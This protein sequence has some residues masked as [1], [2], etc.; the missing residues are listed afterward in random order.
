[1]FT[2]ISASDRE[3]GFTLVELMVVIAIIGIMATMAVPNIISVMPRM[4]LNNNAMILS[5]EI[6]VA[7]MRAI[8]KSSEFRIIFN[9]GG[10]SYT[11]E[12]NTMTSAGP[13]A[14]WVW[15]T[16]G[17]TIMK[18]TELYS[19]TGFK[20]TNTMLA[21][22]MG[23]INVPL[24][25]KAYIILQEPPVPPATEGASQKRITVE[26]MGRMK[27]ERRRAGGS[28]TED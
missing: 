5:N 21:S 9:P 16:I 18:G 24:N 10:N 6:A 27:I 25:S 19:V 1:M 2:A 11:L 17:T 12:K 26:P 7:R 22:Q 15:K 4:K 23:A 20:T 14:V 8:S 13:P 28:W 3:S